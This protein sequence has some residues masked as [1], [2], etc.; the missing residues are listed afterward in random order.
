MDYQ[1][2]IKQRGQEIGRR[3]VRALSALEAIGLVEAQPL[4]VKMPAWD[5][6]GH[7]VRVVR[8]SGFE[9]EARVVG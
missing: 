3:V 5:S 7:A 1:I 6:T 2:I 9:Y 4:N 8:W